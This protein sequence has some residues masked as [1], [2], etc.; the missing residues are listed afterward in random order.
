L[1]PSS[2]RATTAPSSGRGAFVVSLDFELHWGVRDRVSVCDYEENLLGAREAVRWML[3]LFSRYGI[4]ATWATVGFLLFE[5]KEDLIRHAPALKPTYADVRKC[6][7]RDL[8]LIGG[9]ERSDPFHFAPTLV[10]LIAATPHQELATHTFS[11][12]YCLEPGQT[13]LEFA[14]DLRAALAAAERLVGRRPV[15][16]VFPKNQVNEAYLAICTALGIVAY[17]GSERAWYS[18]LGRSRGA[19]L[20]RRALRLLDAYVNVSGSHAFTPTSSRGVPVDVAASRVLR[21]YSPALRIL[22]P[23]RS[24]RI[25]TQMTVAARRGQVFHLWWHPHNFGRN[26]RENLQ[27]LERILVH[28]TRLRR[29]H[30]MRSLSMGEVARERLRDGWL[31]AQ[32]RT[33][34]GDVPRGAAIG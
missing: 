31:A 28:F 22:E 11:H 27:F 23:L 29:E 3:E 19:A 9:D 1:R 24:R 18:R 16:L 10:R 33:G 12:Y 7:Y 30:G 34:N 20:L 32:Q 6:P 17:R 25:A 8:P 15:S 14:D 26:Q 2:R 21:P 13:G 4:H 5:T